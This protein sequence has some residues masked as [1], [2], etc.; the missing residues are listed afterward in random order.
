[1]KGT[2]KQVAWAEEMVNGYVRMMGEEIARITKKIEAGRMVESYTA[3]KADLEEHVEIV[4]S[5]DDAA[6]II[7]IMKQ[8]SKT[9]TNEKSSFSSI[10]FSQEKIAHKVARFMKGYPLELV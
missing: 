6:A 10:E 7:H 1:M 8:Y 2:E 4:K 9:L 5:C 3:Q